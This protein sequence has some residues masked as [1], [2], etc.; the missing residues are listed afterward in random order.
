[1]TPSR[2]ALSLAVGLLMIS[3]VGHA[4]LKAP[5]SAGPALAAPPA[6]SQPVPAPAGP[7]TSPAA[8]SRTDSETAG[9][10][11]ALGWLLLLDRRDWGTAWESASQVF[12][13]QV[14]IATWM[15]AIPKVREPLGALADRQPLEV[16]YKT[17]LP[18]R[19]AGEYVSVVFASKFG[20]KP[21]S[22]EIVT[23]AREADGRWRVI[24]YSTR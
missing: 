11:A 18:G 10:L 19:P 7:A 3:T 9:Q 4:Q 20:N 1:M 24:G 16:A 17:E 5:R 14:P 22:Q 2:T 8:D 13:T 21:D 6:A 15:D 23:T 12:R